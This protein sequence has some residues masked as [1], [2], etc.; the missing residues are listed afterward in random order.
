MKNGAYTAVS[1]AN[2]TLIR[3]IG[4]GVAAGA[5]ARACGLL[6]TAVWAAAG[7]GA[8]AAGAAAGAHAAASSPNVMT[9]Y[10]ARTIPPDRLVRAVYWLVAWSWRG[11]VAGCRILVAGP[12]PPRRR[13]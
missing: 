1:A 4:R 12:A 2:D 13:H 9:R 10:D 6:D 11:S 8:G 7:A 5:A 3:S